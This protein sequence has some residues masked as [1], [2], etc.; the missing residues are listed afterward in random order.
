M[1]CETNWVLLA[2]RRFFLLSLGS[3]LR[4]CC[5]SAAP[6]SAWS[7][8]LPRPWTHCF[9]GIKT[10]QQTPPLKGKTHF[11]GWPKH[12][13]LAQRG[14]SKVC[15]AHRD[16]NRLGCRGQATSL[17]RTGAMAVM[18][19]GTVA[20]VTAAVIGALLCS[21]LPSPYFL[22]MS[23][24]WL[25]EEEDRVMTHPFCKPPADQDKLG[26]HTALEI[27]RCYI[28]AVL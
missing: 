9:S 15:K 14:E 22:F 18:W 17:A 7:V 8:L 4:A 12:F 24:L 25:R 26:A 27:Y 20:Q 13:W 3:K 16:L 6:R 5:F 11:L 19:A 2:L 1:E 28:D 23:C 10:M 21:V